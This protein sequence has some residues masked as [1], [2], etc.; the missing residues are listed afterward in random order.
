M[1]EEV[2]KLG[3]QNTNDPISWKFLQIIVDSHK[4]NVQ[5]HDGLVL[6]FFDIL[7]TMQKKIMIILRVNLFSLHSSSPK[8]RRQAQRTSL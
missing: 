5:Y 2:I 3:E 8:Y 1:K 7:F 6:H 4:T